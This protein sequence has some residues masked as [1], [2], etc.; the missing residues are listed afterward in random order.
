[1]QEREP[2]KETIERGTLFFLWHPGTEQIFSGYGLAMRP[3]SNE[4]LSGLLMVDRP[5]PAD[6][7]WLTEV[8][9]T[10]GECHLV[11]M[12]PAGERGIACQMQIEPDSLP[13]L[14]RFPGEKTAAIQ[15]ALKPLL[16][17]PPKPVF[18][19]CWDEE[20][21]A[22]CSHFAPLA[23]L[24]GQIR[25]VFERTGYGCLAAEANV[26][27]VHVCH[28]ADHDVDGF[29]GKPILYRWQLVKMPADAS[30]PHAPLIRLEVAILDRPSNPY[31]F[32]SFLNVA[33]DDQARVLAELAHQD[34]LYLA[35]YGDD[36]TYRFT[37]VVDHDEQQ[38]QYLDELVA[39]A[40]EYWDRIPPEQRDLNRGKAEF[41][42]RS[43]TWE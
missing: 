20:A 5:R 9:A 37:H 38:W 30:H 41:L 17:Y 33:Q 39:E 29:A 43:G 23:E 22:W 15:T 12:T 36:L 3:G 31:R 26:G 34:R 14:R 35:F 16:E 13:H 2:R 4:L 42:S 11:A 40:V 7:Q 28:A 1:M 8:E 10:F 19:L 6:P 27:V 21:R 25:D 18:T 24:P 32:E